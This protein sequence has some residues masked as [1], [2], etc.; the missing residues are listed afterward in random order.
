MIDVSQQIINRHPIPPRNVVAHS[1]I[2]PARKQDPGEL[3]DWRLLASEGIGLWPNASESRD[4]DFMEMAS[5]Y[6]YD[7]HT[8]KIT[9]AFQRH[10]RPE[11]IDNKVDEKSTC[12]MAG[13]LEIINSQTNH[14]SYVVSD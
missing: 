9:A 13:L 5:V 6:G 3:F 10:F 2:A 8:E 11:I 12:L 14:P 4:R 7:M 1:D